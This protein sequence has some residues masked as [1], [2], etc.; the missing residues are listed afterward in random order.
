MRSSVGASQVT[1]TWTQN[2][3][4]RHKERKIISK[5][6]FDGILDLCDHPDSFI[7]QFTLVPEVIVFFG[8][9][10]L[11]EEACA[12]LSLSSEDVSL[13]QLIS[14]DA[15][16][17]LGDFYLSPIV[18]RNIKLKG[19]PVF[20]IAFFLHR[21]K[22]TSYHQD[23][24]SEIVTKLG[25]EHMTNIPFLTNRE[26]GIR[27]LLERKFPHIPNV[28]H[29]NCVLNNVSTWIKKHRRTNDP[30]VLK[31]HITLL[32]HSS[33]KEEY[34]HN[35]EQCSLL[36]SQTFK[37]YFDKELKDIIPNHAARCFI[38]RFSAFK[39]DISAANNFCESM[40][41][42]IKNKSDWKEM[43][44]DCLIL[45]MYH[46]QK[47][48]LYEFQRAY[49]GLGNYALK[50]QFS[51]LQKTGESQFPSYYTLETIVD[52]IKLGKPRQE[53]MWGETEDYKENQTFQAEFCTLQEDMWGKPED[54]DE[55]Q[56]SLA[57]F[58][59]DSGGVT[60]C[61]QTATFT[62]RDVTGCNTH[63]V[64][65]FPE[66]PICSCAS[67]ELCYHIIATLM[68]IGYVERVKGRHKRAGRKKRKQNL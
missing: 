60:L 26:R 12:L 63:S 28:Y 22:I 42:I 2:P 43:P 11:M 55:N 31:D 19:D 39:N 6:E 25:P 62:V 33:S 30:K 4:Y 50:E 32:L 8:H 54:Y 57:E 45:S 48:F 46:M 16:F 20:P 64:V 21:E 3:L 38:Q 10:E 53:N 34:Q 5:D 37:Q 47:F 9:P 49:C 36:W 59:I 13:P 66:P 41:R 24:L 7:T 15:A 52:S 44:V 58:C 17:K 67:S 18:M 51:Y 27:Q 14:Y 29:W 56:T 1:P 61:P 35:Y 65:L 40:N 68:A 23:F